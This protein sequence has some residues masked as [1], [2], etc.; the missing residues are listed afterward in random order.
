MSGLLNRIRGIDDSADR[1]QSD[2]EA[3]QRVAAEASHIDP[4]VRVITNGAAS[5]VADALVRAGEHA[6]RE[7]RRATKALPC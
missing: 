5:V 6:T 4:V 3:A 7:L 1:R 2:Q